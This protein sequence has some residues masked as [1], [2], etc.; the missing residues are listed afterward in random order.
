MTRDITS[1][2]S[3]ALA[4]SS[5]W[6]QT[7]FLACLN[8]YRMMIG[9]SQQDWDCGAGEFW[10]RVL[11]GDRV[12]V[13]VHRTCPLLLIQDSWCNIAVPNNKLRLLS[14]SAWDAAS[15][16]IDAAMLEKLSGGRYKASECKD[17]ELNLDSLSAWD[18]WWLTI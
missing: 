7:E 13:C 5:D 16:S 11:V 2:V 10:G 12:A 15:F 3:A 18:V 17:L 14:F 8:D 6:S 1:V 4:D 9:D